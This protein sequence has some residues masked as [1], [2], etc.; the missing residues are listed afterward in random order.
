[1]SI[2]KSLLCNNVNFLQVFIWG[3]DFRPLLRV[4]DNLL[5]MGEL[6][7]DDLIYVLRLID[8][9]AFDDHYIPGNYCSI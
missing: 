1:M 5:V 4:V 8:P 6:T 2:N 3:C 7:D 9:E